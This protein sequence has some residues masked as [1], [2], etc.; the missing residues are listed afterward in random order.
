MRQRS[1]LLAT[2]ILLAFLFPVGAFA[3]SEEWR[4]RGT[5]YFS[6]LYVAGSEDQAERYAGFADQLYDEVASSF[7]HRV[8]TPIKLRLYPDLE[9]YYVAN[10]RARGMTGV[11][12]HADFRRNEVVVIVDQ[13]V[14]QSEEEVHN[15]IRHELTHMIAAE[16]SENR[17]NPGLQEGLAQYVEKPTPDLD[18]KID[19]LR[20]ALSDR[21]LLPWSAFD[22]R[23]LVYRDP[24][25]SYPQAL[26]VVTYL[27]QRTSFARV[28][29]FLSI[30][31][32]SSGY[33]S[34]MQRAFGASSDELERDW[35]AWLP[36]YVAGGYRAGVGGYDL[37]RAE[38]LL[39]DGDY[40]GALRELEVAAA[41]LRAVGRDSEAA[42]ADRLRETSQAGIAAD[43]LARRSREA[44]LALDYAGAAEL[45]EQARIAYLA[46]GD[47]RQG[48]V[49][50]EYLARA[51][52]GQAAAQWLTDAAALAEALRYPQ[53]RA[54]A[55]RAAAE[56]AALGDRDRAAQALALRG[57]LDQRQTIL[58]GVLLLLGA[59]GIALSIAR[60]FLAPEPEPW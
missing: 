12:A 52:R 6:I 27:A 2:L 49:L 5:S 51:Q 41:G 31:A 45:A 37:A 57:F 42:Y 35:L 7:G 34:A 9:Q 26:S 50:D 18:H 17:L 48:A 44:L 29:D 39:A 20:T 56:Y 33:R 4:E 54:L 47:T 14:S 30:S 60:R 43:D 10:P 22:D 11:V 25:V 3:Q 1:L 13:T 58:G 38:Q 36:S 19:L 32:S 55:D 59:G 24:E 21:R 8:A 15:T 16:L 28:V 23:D 53:A 46:I 40:T